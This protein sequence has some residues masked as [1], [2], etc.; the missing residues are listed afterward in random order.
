MKSFLLGI[1][2]ALFVAGAVFSSYWFGKKTVLNQTASTPTTTSTPQLVGGDRDSHDCIGS[3]GYSW[4]EP[5]SKCLRIWEEGCPAPTDQEE[6]TA[7]LYAKNNWPAGLVS[8]TLTTDDGKYAGGTV[9]AQ[10]G[11]GYF[12]A[13]K[14]NNKWVIVADGNGIIPCESLTAF[15]DFPV[16]L[17][18]ECYNSQTGKTVIRK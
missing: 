4:C 14:V 16:S 6:I 9:A 18:P 13:A 7:A 10:G 17:I 11:G 12:Y 15:P 2:F 1:S 3:A 5:K 8:V